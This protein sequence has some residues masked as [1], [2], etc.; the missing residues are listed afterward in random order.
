MNQDHDT[1]TEH[2]MQIDPPHSTPQAGRR[3][4]VP[5]VLG[6]SIA[7][8]AVAVVVFGV[9]PALRRN[10]AMARDA[11]A[12]DSELT[13]VVFVEAI[14]APAMARIT[15]PARLDALQE[16][17]LYAQVTGYL[18]P[19]LA[20]IGDK[21]TAGQPLVQIA[22]PVL[23]RQ[24]EQRV[25]ARNVA[26][27]KIA[28]A[29][30]RLDFSHATLVRMRSVGDARAVSQQAVDE[31]AANEKSDAASLAAARADRAAVEADGDRL[32]AQRLL[33]RIVAP[34]DGEIT[35]RSFDAGTLVVADRIDA[36]LPIFRVTNRS[37]IRAFIDVPQSFASAVTVDQE[38]EFTVR[39]HP[40]R[41]FKA[42]ITRAV[43]E[44]ERASRTRLVEARIANVDRALLPGM[45]AEAT[46]LIPHGAN[47]S[48]IP[49]EAV[50]IR[51]GKQVV[52]VVDAQDALHY[53]AVELGRDNGTQV[54]VV[55]G[56][57]AGTRVVTNLSRQLSDGTK[58]APVARPV[59]K[60]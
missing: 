23:D 43:P 40:G 46:I 33:A 52:A 42:T 21:V 50:V 22:T 8:I 15:L 57:A 34:F 13:R 16:T 28:L 11:A 36:T 51:E 12:R 1:T 49:G 10:A 39:E 59:V 37:E 18:G 9:L 30:A 20:D 5:I 60:K 32:E 29:Q 6:I 24:V 38:I 14:P 2:S 53:V 19:M 25:S 47:V 45:F 26:D 58:V 48:L 44:L 4:T 55:S 41:K 27:A 35:A 3:N 56:M 54:E 17:A 31:A 7:A